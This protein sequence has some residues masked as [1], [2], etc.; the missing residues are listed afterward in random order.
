MVLDSG[1]ELEIFFRRSYFFHHYR[2]W[3]QQRSLTSLKIGLLLKDQVLNRINRI[4][5]QVINRAGKIADLG[6]IRV[7]VFG[8]GPQTPTQLS[9][10]NSKTVQPQEKLKFYL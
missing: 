4:F 6:L 5:G 9:Q 10:W 1:L 3:H 2:Y 8:R 7:R